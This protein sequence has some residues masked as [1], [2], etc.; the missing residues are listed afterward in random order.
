MLSVDCWHLT[1][2]PPLKILALYKYVIDMGRKKLLFQVLK[3][4]PTD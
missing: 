3:K 1:E 2:Y 4:Y